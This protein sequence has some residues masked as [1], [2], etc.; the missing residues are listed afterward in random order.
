M[1][2][3]EVLIMKSKITSVLAML[4]VFFAIFGTG[5]AMAQENETTDDV[6]ET[7][8]DATQVGDDTS[9]D[10]K[11]AEDEVEEDLEELMEET[12]EELTEAEEEVTGAEE[13]IEEEGAG[14][15]DTTQA[16]E[17]NSEA[18]S[19]V[20][21]A[22]A[23]FVAGDYK[24]ARKLAHDAK[25]KAL[26]AKRGKAFKKMKLLHLYDVFF[27]QMEKHRIG[28]EAIIEYV[29][30]KGADSGQ[31]VT[32]KDD[33][34]ALLADIETAA[35]ADDDAEF[36]SVLK[37]ARDLTKEFKEASH[38]TLGGEGEIGEAR[39]KVNE[40]L[41]ANADYLKTLK[42]NIQNSREESELEI[43]D[44]I[45]EEIEDRIEKAK[46]EGADTQELEAK[47]EE[48]KDKREE[49]EA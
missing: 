16:E 37:D 9:E 21:E 13:E 25:K 1:K 3:Q 22:R 41:D 24:K 49:L 7:V 26:Q 42:N 34:V 36:K 45:N 18:N 20:D 35:N 4:L 17:Y 19:L 33:F 30:E 6:A 38:D 29:D 31:L 46:E 12:E 14:G 27:L 28:M 43:V 39:T 8:D 15:A 11:D 2:R 48:L 5:L 40:A 23:A 32:I 10:L 44:D 47:L